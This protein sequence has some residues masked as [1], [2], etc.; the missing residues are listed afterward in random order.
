MRRWPERPAMFV[1]DYDCM[2]SEERIARLEHVTAGW[3]E[4]SRKDYEENRRLWREQ[5]AEFATMR[6]ETEAMRQETDRRWRETDER[7]RETAERSRQTDERVDK[8]VLAIGEL[9][10]RLDLQ[11]Q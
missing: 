9:V 10:R 11:H 7:F 5:Q 8:L 4:Q 2:T 1:R 6:K 3:I